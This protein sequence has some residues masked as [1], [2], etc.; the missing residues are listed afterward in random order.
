MVLEH[1]RHRQLDALAVEHGHFAVGLDLEIDPVLGNGEQVG[2]VVP[3]H[4]G[5]KGLQTLLQRHHVGMT[6]MGLGIARP[7]RQAERAQRDS[8]G[9]TGQRFSVS[10]CKGGEHSGFL[11][12]SR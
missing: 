10:Q 4:R 8:Q 12:K 9:E 7:V 11:R 5:T 1:H 3:F 6:A 2:V